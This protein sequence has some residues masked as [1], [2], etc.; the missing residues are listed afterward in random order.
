MPFQVLMPQLG[1]SVNEGTLTKWLKVKGEQIEEFEPL[2]EVNTDKVDTEI[3][4]PASGYLLDILIDEGN[5]VEAGT[6]LAWIGEPE[7]EIPSGII[8]PETIP[9]INVEMEATHVTDEP[10]IQ[11]RVP[12]GQPAGGRDR[13]L[14]FIS[15]VV[16]NIASENNV[17]LFKI[18]GT[19]K[20]GRITKNDILNY[21]DQPSSK[22][23]SN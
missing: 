5:T 20:N 23:A 10:R 4:S 15:P 14:G 13:T 16:A 17:D 9:G 11:S 8:S 18:T 22:D 2:L 19:G 7:D 3:P 21:L 6:L 1:E 12:S